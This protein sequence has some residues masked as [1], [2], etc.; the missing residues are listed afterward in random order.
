MVGRPSNKELILEKLALIADEPDSTSKLFEFHLHSDRLAN[1]LTNRY[2]HTPYSILLHGEWGSGKNSLL[3]QTFELV[4]SKTK[5]NNEWKVLWFDAWEYEKVDPTS[6]LLN[7]I[8]NEYKDRNS[9]F[10]ELSKN[11]SLF[12]SDVALRNTIGM[13]VNEFRNH[14]ESTME[15]IPTITQTL[16]KMIGD[17]RLIVFIDDLDRCMIDNVLN[18]MEAVKLFLNAKG[19]LFIFAVDKNKIERAWELR[20]KS[21]A[22]NLEGKEHLDKI[23]QMKLSLELTDYYPMPKNE[24]KDVKNHYMDIIKRNLKLL[25]EQT[26][27]KLINSFFQKEYPRDILKQA[28][29]FQKMPSSA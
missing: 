23:F 1:V 27:R 7:A 20:Y 15:A 21:N 28:Q 17:G 14:F 19:I 29:D 9:K 10:K 24:L 26:R 16:E 13:S 8:A 2:T 18:I 25:D 3:K 6:A 5:Q 4:K 11:L 12:V 22:G